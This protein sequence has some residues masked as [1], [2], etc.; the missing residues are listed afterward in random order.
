ME[1]PQ[2]VKTE[3]LYDPATPLQD[4]YPKEI[5]LLYGRHICTLLF[6]KASFM[7]TKIQKEPKYPST[8]K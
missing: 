3:L 7:T 8:H 5:K 2:N 4:V 1:V 6:I